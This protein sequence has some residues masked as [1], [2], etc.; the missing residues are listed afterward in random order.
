MKTVR[1][2]LR[3]KGPDVW[4]IAPDASVYEA[5]KLM[6]DKNLGALIVKQND[7]VNGLISERD[8]ARKIILRGRTSRDTS[9]KDIMVT[10]VAFAEPTQT[11]EECMALMTDKHIRHLPVM[12]SGELIGMLS[13]GDLVKAVIA[14]QRFMIEQ[15][16]HYISG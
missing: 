6:A 10:H 3:E 4:S 8:Y 7:Q 16:E 1:D 5:L 12:E 11:L 15:L 9:V 14:E 2:L 13:I